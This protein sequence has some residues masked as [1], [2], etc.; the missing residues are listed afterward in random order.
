MDSN[1]SWWSVSFVVEED[2]ARPLSHQEIFDVM[3]P[4]GVRMIG[5]GPSGVGESEDGQAAHY[6]PGRRRGSAA[7]SG[8]IV[9]SP[10]NSKARERS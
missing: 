7:A 1:L 10:Q 3:H 9:G 8:Y 5:V 2:E 6:P 4:K